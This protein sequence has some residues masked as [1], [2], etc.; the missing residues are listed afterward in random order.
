VARRRGVVEELWANGGF[1][2]LKRLTHEV[3]QPYLIGFALAESNLPARKMDDLLLQCLQVDDNRLEFVARGF[4]G[5]KLKREKDAGRG[6]QWGY[7]LHVSSCRRFTSAF[8]NIVRGGEDLIRLFIEK[9]M[10][11]AVSLR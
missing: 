11:G 2:D 5:K 8:S 3:P 4:I 7:K 1:E 10:I 9:E 6:E